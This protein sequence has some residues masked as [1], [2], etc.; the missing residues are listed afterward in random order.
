MS[1]RPPTEEA[2]AV[3]LIAG[4][5]AMVVVIVVEAVTTVFSGLVPETVA[6][7]TT[8]PASMSAWV[9]VWV[10]VQVSDAPTASEDEGQLIAFPEVPDAP[11][12]VSAR[13]PVFVT[14][15]LYGMVSPILVGVAE[16]VPLMEIAGLMAEIV[17]EQITCFALA[18]T[19]NDPDAVEP[20]PM[21]TPV[22]E[23]PVHAT[24]CH[25]TAYLDRSVVPA[26]ATVKA[27]L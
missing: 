5:F 7:F 12:E 18:G 1:P 15:K 22:N 16:V 19:V 13:L 21:V 3:S 17:T 9:T 2:E 20:E 23:V 27:K 11:T 10:A 26:D 8:L 14:V 25:E 4:L 24:H 6:K